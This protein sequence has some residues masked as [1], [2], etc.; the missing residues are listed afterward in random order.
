MT[1]MQ[2]AQYSFIFDISKIIYYS[3]KSSAA[4]SGQFTRR[5]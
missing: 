5:D 3:I 4:S 1:M 2:Q